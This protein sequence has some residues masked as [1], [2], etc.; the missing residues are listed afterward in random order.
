MFFY[1]CVLF[2]KKYEWISPYHNIAE[3]TH[4]EW[5]HVFNFLGERMQNGVEWILFFLGLSPGLAETWCPTP[6]PVSPPQLPT[7]KEISQTQEGV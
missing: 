5:Q 1:Q 4:A 2:L 7:G 3:N 6:T